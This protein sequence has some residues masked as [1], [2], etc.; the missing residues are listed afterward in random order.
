MK[1][2]ETLITTGIFQQELKNRFRCV[3]K[4][5]DIDEV[6]YVSAS[7][8]LEN[9]IDLHN[10][11]VQLTPSTN[12]SK[13][14]HTLFAVYKNNEKKATILNLSLAN[15]VVFEQLHR[16]LFSFL[17]SRKLARR[18]VLVEGYKADIFIEDTKTA[19]EIKTI[20]AS[21]RQ[22]NFPSVKSERGLKQLEQIKVLLKKGYRVCYMFVSLRPE[23]LNTQL[24]L[25]VVIHGKTDDLPVITVQNCCQIQLAVLTLDLRDI[26]QPLPVG[27]VCGKIPVNQVLR[28]L[29]SQVRFCQT[30]GMTRRTM[31]QTSTLHGPPYAASAYR[32]TALC[33]RQKDSAD[34]VVIIVWIFFVN[35]S[36]FDQKQLPRFWLASRMQ[37]AVVPGFTDFHNPAHGMNAEPL[38]AQRDVLIQPLWLYRFRSLA[39]KPSASLRIS[40]AFRSS[41][42][43]LISRRS[44]SESGASRRMPLPTKA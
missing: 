5:D 25:H 17:G 6:C 10:K 41:A 27:S 24:L 4:V 22:A 20:I 35:L 8:R 42:I 12:S 33:K 2:D 26:R 39:K 37:R 44:F 16:R 9:F 19:I 38:T 14:Q 28:L 18:E 32:D 31:E 1:I 36:Y 34:A 3:V 29:R 11:E 21:S 7:C 40:F 43:S 15:A 23:S 13:L 30:V